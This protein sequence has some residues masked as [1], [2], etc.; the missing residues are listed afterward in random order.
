ME[1]QLKLFRKA[2]QSFI[3]IWCLGILALFGIFHFPTLFQA[4]PEVLNAQ[5][6][7]TFV[8]RSYPE[9]AGEPGMVHDVDAM[10]DGTY[11]TYNE[12]Y[13][14][15][16]C[17]DTPAAPTPQ[18]TTVPYVVR[19]Y[20]EC[21]GGAGQVHEVDQLSDGTYRRYNQHYQS[22]VCGDTGLSNQPHQNL[23]Q[24]Q[25]STPSPT[26]II[27]PVTAEQ[28]QCEGGNKVYY[29]VY[30]NVVRPA[31]RTSRVEYNHP[32]CTGTVPIS[33]DLI[34]SHHVSSEQLRSHSTMSASC[35]ASPSQ[36][37]VGE[38]VTW[39]V[40]TN[41]GSGSFKYRWKGDNSVSGRDDQIFST[42]YSTAG[43]RTAQIE[44]IDRLSNQK[45]TTDCSVSVNSAQTPIPVVYRGSPMIQNT[46]V[47]PSTQPQIQVVNHPPVQCPAGTTEKSRSDTQLLC[48][49]PQ[50]IVTTINA[51]TLASCPAG[52]TE[53]GRVNGVIQCEQSQPSS[54]IVLATPTPQVQIVP[55]SGAV[56]T[57][58]TMVQCPVGT[59]EKSRTSAQLICERQI[60][61]ASVVQIPP[62]ATQPEVKVL[63]T[64]SSVI[65]ELPRT[66]LPL[67]AIGIGALGPVGWRIKKLLGNKSVE[68]SAND[69]WLK[70]QLG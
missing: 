62:T 58:Q 7:D 53:K 22:G 38:T 50:P 66:G 2:G 18:P 12:H 20:P 32:N 14:P 68:E 55:A 24:A 40:Q 36:A 16:V 57:S 35:A 47:Y 8:I 46:S 9:C 64:Q 29:R 25:T 30:I 63:G 70:K 41:G 56:I 61:Q 51:T 6:N 34:R 13:Q 10:S 15:G 65:R 60:T 44:I 49:R 5:E 59:I 31:E 17:G 48:E 67:V 39:Q 21:A 37:L 28:Y 33:S 27:T 3:F 69:I 23:S 1:H 26:S 54:F 43:T 42:T 11:R 52:T 4:G 45:I 19:S